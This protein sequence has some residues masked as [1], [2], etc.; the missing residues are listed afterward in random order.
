MTT[1]L[2]AA[3]EARLNNALS[4]MFRY[5]EGVMTR[6]QY[7]DKYAIR[8]EA[9]EQPKYQY[10][11]RKF[12]NMNYDEQAKYEAKLKLTKTEYVAYGADDSFITIPKIVFEHYTA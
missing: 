7:L 3:N 6:K 11:R 8:F 12:N 5:S 2:N 4:K 10:N 1:Q 9:M